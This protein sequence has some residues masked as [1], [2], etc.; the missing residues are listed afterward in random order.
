MIAADYE[1]T[2]RKYGERGKRY[3]HIE[4]GHAAQNIY[5][6]A[7]ALGIGTT[8]V[9]AFLDSAVAKV[10]GVKDDETPLAILP[11]GKPR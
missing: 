1:R 2:S 5:L 4:V 8:M 11:L 3:V 7:E 10:V 6:Q 9:G